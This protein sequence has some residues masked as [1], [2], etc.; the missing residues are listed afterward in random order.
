MPAFDIVS[1]VDLHQATNAVDQATR[2]IKNRFDFKGVDA[3]FVRDQRQITMTADA[4]FQ[5]EQEQLFAQLLEQGLSVEV[6]GYVL[7]RSS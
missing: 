4:E 5:L 6:E 7:F 2:I 3:S 1:E